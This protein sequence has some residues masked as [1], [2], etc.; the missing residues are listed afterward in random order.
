VASLIVVDKI[1]EELFK[2]QKNCEDSGINDKYSSEIP[3]TLSKPL[4]TFS[5]S[6]SWNHTDY[7]EFDHRIDIIFFKAITFL[8]EN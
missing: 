2:M 7:R 5:N 1:M 8:L 6:H 4:S 3:V